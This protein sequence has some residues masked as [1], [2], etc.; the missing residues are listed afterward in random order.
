MAVPH[1]WC[2]INKL[3]MC[4]YEA[5][6]ARLDGTWW[7]DWRGALTPDVRL[8]CG[9]LSLLPPRWLPLP[10]S[11]DPSA[12]NHSVP[13]WVFGVLQK[14]CVARIPSEMALSRHDIHRYRPDLHLFKILLSRRPL[15]TPMDGTCPSPGEGT[16]CLAAKV[17]TLTFLRP[18]WLKPLLPH[19]LFFHLFPTSPYS[20]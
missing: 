18:V 10:D 6:G 1:R 20:V 8:H 16:L 7:G 17:R 12:S 3:K 13:H 2:L 15:P 14:S 5:T 11:G 19:P 9:G 4:N